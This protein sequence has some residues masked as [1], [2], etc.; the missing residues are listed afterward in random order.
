MLAAYGLF[1]WS[2]VSSCGVQQDLRPEDVGRH[3]HPRPCD[4]PVHVRF[5][6]E[7]HDSVARVL[8][9]RRQDR[10]SVADV[11][12]DEMIRGMVPDAVKVLQVAGVRELVEIHEPDPGVRLEK[13]ADEIAPDEAGPPRHEN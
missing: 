8:L 9:H 13:M 3:K 7:M 6:R 12:A 10:I 5:G 4:A 1:G 2:G 11:P